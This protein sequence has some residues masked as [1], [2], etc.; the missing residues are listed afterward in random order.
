LSVWCF[1]LWCNASQLPISGVTMLQR[2][3]L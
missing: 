2:K 3:I 1:W